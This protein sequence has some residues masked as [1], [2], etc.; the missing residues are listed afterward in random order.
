MPQ[1]RVSEFASL[2]PIQRLQETQRAIDPSLHEMHQQLM[3][4]ADYSASTKEV[5]LL[6]L[7][8]V[9]ISFNR[10]FRNCKRIWNQLKTE[11][12]IFKTMFLEFNKSSN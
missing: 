4:M 3:D 6:T 2:T 12:V 1:D 10:P 9:L 5:I 7:S 8:N 11:E